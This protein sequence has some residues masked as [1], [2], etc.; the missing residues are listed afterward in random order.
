MP[1]Y[2]NVYV[3]HYFDDEKLLSL[4]VNDKG[5]TKVIGVDDNFYTVE[6]DVIAYID[7]LMD[8]VDNDKTE[9]FDYIVDF[10]RHL[11]NTGVEEL[12][13]EYLESFDHPIDEYGVY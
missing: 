8:A 5:H 6:E 9:A 13:K 4:Y 2:R 11:K 10:L 12:N 1:E 7:I 3:T